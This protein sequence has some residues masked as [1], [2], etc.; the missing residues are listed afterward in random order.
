MF[1]PSTIRSLPILTGIFALSSS[2]YAGDIASFS[3]QTLK[4]S[5]NDHGK[6][7]SLVDQ[8][9]QSDY[10]SK[11]G[12]SFLLQIQRWDGTQNP[13]NNPWHTPQSAKVIKQSSSSTLLELSYPKGEKLE[14]EIVKKKGYFVM[15]LLKATPL[16]AISKI[17]WGQ[18]F[19][20]MREPIGDYIG[21][22]RSKTFSIG[23]LSLEPN[24]D[25][26]GWDHQTPAAYDRGG[27][28]LRQYSSDRT[29]ARAL[30]Q[31]C[32]YILSKPV[33]GVT[34][35]GSKVAMFGVPSGRE[36]ELDQI[37]K[38][39]LAENLP[40]PMIDGKW[41]KRS[42]EV[43]N[44]TL[45]TTVNEKEADKAISLAKDFGASSICQFHGFF[46]N[47]GTFEVKEVDFPHG[48]EGLKEIAEKATSSG[49]HNSVYTLT[50]FTKPMSAPEPLISPTPDPRLAKMSLDSQVS[51]SSA[52][53]QE[54][55]SFKITL[56]HGVTDSI[57]DVCNNYRKVL[58]IDNEMIEVKSW[59][60]VDQKTILCETLTR[61]G[62][63]TSPANHKSGSDVDLMYVSGYNNFYPGDLSLTLEEADNIARVA[64]KGKC[65]KV[66][67]DGYESILIAGL[68]FYGKNVFIDRLQQ[69]LGKYNG[70]DNVTFTGS[71]MGNYSWHLMS[72]QSWGEFDTDK[73]FRGTQLEIRLKNQVR[74]R[75]SL[76]PNK[77]GQ[78]YP[79]E[80]TSLEDMHWLC[81]QIAGWDAG[82]DFGTSYDSL[83]KNP[84]YEELVRIFRLWD[85]ARKK[86]VFTKLEMLNLRQTT[87][88]FGL[89]KDKEG[90]FK[91]NF[92]RHW[93]DGRAKVRPSSVVPVV[94]LDPH[95]KVQP[96]SVDWKW[97]HNPAVYSSVAL[98]DDLVASS[99]SPASWNLK[100][101]EKFESKEQNDFPFR[102][103]IR[104]NPQSESGAKN[105]RIKCNGKL[106]DICH[107]ELA[108]N[109]YL[110]IPHNNQYAYV[111]DNKTH[112]VKREVFIYQDCPYWFLPTLYRGKE[113]KIEL[114]FDSVDP[115]KKAEILLNVQ[116]FE[117][118][119]KK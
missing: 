39:E 113:N 98:T 86:K 46:K 69:K 53:T 36:N 16:E 52:I 70:K 84:Q 50:T 71:N 17:R 102:V 107:V 62:W 25:G 51:L 29:Q 89:K 22:N 44:L 10:L 14:V 13:K 21:L 45:W 18:Y 103:I 104:M 20:S 65:G 2:L 55:A 28:V 94:A 85:E 9:T 48:L 11:K 43:K 72:V 66:V 83:H 40:H 3:T 117:R 61:G 34:V 31:S 8:Q 60:A 1:I 4:W 80:D 54:S 68:D 63:K 67:L 105:I 12:E 58:K 112:Q 47:W 97:T 23:L 81:N 15:T 106:L 91:L 100:V 82:A 57:K 49:I 6:L 110:A 114:S 38:I 90:K 77:L 95:S 119:Y 111:Y 78:Y 37:E 59:K 35:V 41:M 108:K 118:Y 99:T 19:T 96:V 75:N 42:Q 87:S 5:V 26:E 116:F 93:I 74:L 109:E 27:S 32:Q 115:Q 30:E 33:P 64:L 92:I 24:T 56:S 7:T 88:V 76:V 73:G 101:P 79:K